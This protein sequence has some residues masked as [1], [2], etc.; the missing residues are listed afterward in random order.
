MSEKSRIVNRKYDKT[1]H[2]ALKRRDYQL[3]LR[4]SSLDLYNNLF[5]DQNGCC[6][7]CGIHQSKIKGRNR[8]LD[9]DHDHLTKKARGLLCERHN[10]AIGMF[11]DSIELLRKAA[12]YLEKY[13]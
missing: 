8:A 6:A 4:G 10:R 7:I 1:S 2:G 13:K 5:V 11:G 9:Q 12:D 3:F